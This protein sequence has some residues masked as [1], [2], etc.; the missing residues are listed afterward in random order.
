MPALGAVRDEAH[1]V[2]A[3]QVEE[4]SAE[5][6]EGVAVVKPEVR[7]AKAVRLMPAGKPE[8]SLAKSVLLVPVGKPEVRHAKAVLL[9]L[10]CHARLS[11]IDEHG[12]FKED[13]VFM[14]KK[15]QTVRKAK[16]SAKNLMLS[17]RKLKDDGDEEMKAFFRDIEVMQQ[18][19]AF[20]DGVINAWLAELRNNEP[21]QL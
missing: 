18:P 13:E 6:A 11:N 8:V 20:C 12:R 4:A 16:T 2:D 10:G 17:W 19:N 5:G 1:V 7:H 3:M 14:V 9:V 21:G 15:K